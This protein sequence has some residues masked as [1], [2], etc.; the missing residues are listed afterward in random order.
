MRILQVNKYYYPRGGAEQHFL[1]LKDLLE[2]HGH[3]VAVFSMDH[4][5]NL[6]T[7]YQ[8]YFVSNLDT[9]NF[10]QLSWV[11]KIKGAGRI[12]YSRE[13]K[14]KIKSLLQNEKVDIA[15][16][17]NIYHHLSPSIL[18]ELKKRQ[19]PIVMTIHD[20]KLLVPNYTFFHH[21]QIHEEDGR[22]WYA[23]C[24]KNRCV[25]DSLPASALFT[26]EMIIHHKWKKYYEKYVD[27]LIAPSQFIRDLFIRFGWPG[28]KIV[29][30]PHFLPPQLQTAGKP[31]KAP[32]QPRFAFF[33]RLSAE[34]GAR[35]L[36]EYWIKN[37]ISYPLDIYGRG[38]QE[39]EIADMVRE[40]A[41]GLITMKGFVPRDELY[42]GFA[43]DYTAAIVPSLFYEIFGLVAL[44]AMSQGLPVVA[45]RSGS[46]I[47]LIENSQAGILYDWQGEGASLEAALEAV[48][49]KRFRANALAYTSR[50]HG[51]GEYIEKLTSLYHSLLDKGISVSPK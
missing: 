3:T 15:H 34:K 11:N 32:V 21:G 31:A 47:E 8:K 33:G 2:E 38:P 39:K 20:Y 24:I 36:V 16:L 1:D 13:A 9:D 14:K 37:R 28:E 17:H 29:F 44:E 40:R 12:I 26:L 49:D 42:L 27:L 46:L 6:P 19:I 41:N 50:H 18:P 10:G 30:L 22:G 48:Q 25:K 5:H 7:P 35:R 43:K 4:P 23:T 45:S 51:T